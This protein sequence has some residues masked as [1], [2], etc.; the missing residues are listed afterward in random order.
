SA[1]WILVANGWMQSPTGVVLKNGLFQVTN[2]WTAIFNPNFD[3]GFPHM[4]I[5]TLELA[6]FFFAA[7]SAWFI[8]KNRHADLFTTLLKPT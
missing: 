2:W 1:M 4:W 6:L 7:V 8:L 5:A 3:I